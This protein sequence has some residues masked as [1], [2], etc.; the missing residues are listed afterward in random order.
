MVTGGV[1]IEFDTRK[2]ASLLQHHTKFEQW[3]HVETDQAW[4]QIHYDAD[5][6]VVTPKMIFDFFRVEDRDAQLKTNLAEY[7]GMQPRTKSMVWRSENEWRMLWHN[8]ETRLKIYRVAIPSDAITK[9]IFGLE[10]QETWKKILSLRR[11]ESFQKQRS[12]EPAKS[13]A[14]LS[15][16]LVWWNRGDRI[17]A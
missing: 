11:N 13:R 10:R 7:Y 16:S 8:D 12:F 9:C 5:I 17:P 15:W 3:H 14:F 1:A 4:I 6:G 2:A